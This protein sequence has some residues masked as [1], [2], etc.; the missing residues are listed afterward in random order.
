MPRWARLGSSERFLREIQALVADIAETS[1]RIENALKVTEDVYWNRVYSAA[2][3][4]LRVQVWRTG[5]TEALDVLR[6]MADLVHEEAHVAWTT[7]L[8]ILVIVLIAVELV[9]A[10]VGH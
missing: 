7:L 1:G 2:L 9:V 4:V 3:T 10:I 8:E 6:Q 5:I